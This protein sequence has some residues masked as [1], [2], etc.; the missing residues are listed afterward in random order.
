MSNIEFFN[1]TNYPDEPFLDVMEF[2]YQRIDTLWGFEGDV[3]VRANYLGKNAG[4]D[5]ITCGSAYKM[6][7]LFKKLIGRRTRQ[8]AGREGCVSEYCGR[9]QIM[10]TQDG[11]L[12]WCWFG[13]PKTRFHLSTFPAKQVMEWIAHEMIHIWQFRNIDVTDRFLGY[14]TPY[15]RRRMRHRDRPIERFTQNQLA[16][17]G[18]MDELNVKRSSDLED[19]LQAAMEK[20]LGIVKRPVVNKAASIT[21]WKYEYEE[22]E[23]KVHMSY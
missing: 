3:A 8:F 5:K 23:E 11:S 7:P 22:P 12:G 1:H 2:V 21:G 17:F 10:A 20:E 13:V 15:A 16:E 18:N 14:A 6:P 9:A 19:R 4:F